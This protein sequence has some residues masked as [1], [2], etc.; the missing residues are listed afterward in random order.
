M[1]PILIVTVYL[2]FALIFNKI[3]AYNTAFFSKGLI[4]CIKKHN[5]EIKKTNALIE[6]ND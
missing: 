3:R 2:S 4:K 1:L 6:I 5:S